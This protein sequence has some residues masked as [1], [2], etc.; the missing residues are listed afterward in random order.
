[1]RAADAV[2]VVSRQLKANFQRRRV[3]ARNGAKVNKNRV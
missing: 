1:M 2:G 3:I